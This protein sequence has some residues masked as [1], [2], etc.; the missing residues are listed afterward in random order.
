MEPTLGNSAPRGTKSDV[1]A[2]DDAR[3]RAMLA[4]DADALAHLLSEDLVYTHS[5]GTCDNK[6][7]YLAAV[8]TRIFDYRRCERESTIFQD[9]GNVALMHGTVLLEAV[10]A[11]RPLIL[12]S[13]YLAVWIQAGTSGWRLRAW[14][15]TPIAPARLP[16]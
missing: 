5:N 16:S 2:I 7:D 15:S 12:H 1:L 14:A 8:R 3:Y 6:D 9:A 13:Q 10:V 4:G 11:G